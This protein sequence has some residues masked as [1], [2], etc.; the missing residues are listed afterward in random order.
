MLDKAY[1][2]LTGQPRVRDWI[3]DASHINVITDPQ[4]IISQQFKKNLCGVFYRSMQTDGNRDAG[5]V[6]VNF[7]FQNQKLILHSRQQVSDVWLARAVKFYSEYSP[8]SIYF[9]WSVFP[10]PHCLYFVFGK[11]IKSSIQTPTKVA[12]DY[13][14]LGPR[15]QFGDQMKL[16]QIRQVN[17]AFNRLFHNP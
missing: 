12:I 9:S 6:S 7:K 16:Q 13:I 8:T 11:T 5:P 14:T 2:D 17:L 10:L 15:Q 3:V 1:K 4:Q